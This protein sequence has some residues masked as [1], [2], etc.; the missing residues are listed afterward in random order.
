MY[1]EYLESCLK[2]NANQIDVSASGARD[3]GAGAG[4]AKD[5]V[6]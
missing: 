1:K 2:G 6:S 5:K 4:A 3:G